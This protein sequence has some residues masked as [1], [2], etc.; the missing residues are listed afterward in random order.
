MGSIP[1]VN[2]GCRRRSG[3]TRLLFLAL[4]TR[5]LAKLSHFQPQFGLSFLL[6]AMPGLVAIDL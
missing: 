6:P 1:L 2:S 3:K 4:G 5:N